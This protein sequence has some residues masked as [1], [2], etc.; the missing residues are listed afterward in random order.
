MSKRRE[1]GGSSVS[2]VSSRNCARGNSRVETRC[3]ERAHGARR[4][5]TDFL[6]GKYREE[7]TLSSRVLLSVTTSRTS[8]IDARP[9]ALCDVDQA[10]QGRATRENV[11]LADKRVGELAVRARIRGL[12]SVIEAH[13]MCSRWLSVSTTW[14]PNESIYLRLSLTT[15][16]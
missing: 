1:H 13:A 4:R 16:S 8:N 7:S 14:P 5:N 9:G 10:G 11:R 3:E 2:M 6:R 15:C 12:V